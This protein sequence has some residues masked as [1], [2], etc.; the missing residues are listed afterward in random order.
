MQPLAKKSELIKLGE[1][2]TKNKLRKIDKTDLEII[3]KAFKILSDPKSTEILKKEEYE[4]LKKTLSKKP[5]STSRGVTKLFRNIHLPWSLESKTHR[6]MEKAGKVQL[7]LLEDQFYGNSTKEGRK[8][9]DSYFKENKIDPYSKAEFIELT[10]PF[11]QGAGAY[12]KIDLLKLFYDEIPSG[13]LSKV[14]EYMK[15]RRSLCNEHL[16]TTISYIRDH[17][18]VDAKPQLNILSCLV[19]ID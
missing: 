16:L 15:I 12:E 1:G 11:L 17:F 18:G 2:W 4:I 8:R 7:R 13:D 6:R 3:N 10:L 19:S 9:I 5:E 14:V